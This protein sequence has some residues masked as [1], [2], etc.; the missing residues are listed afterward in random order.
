M[1]SKSSVNLSVLVAGGG[2]MLPT[3]LRKYGLIIPGPNSSGS[4]LGGRNFG[5]VLGRLV[6]FLSVSAGWWCHSGGSTESRRNVNIKHGRV[7]RWHE[8]MKPCQGP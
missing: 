4:N 6:G 8:S 5:C 3:T 7:S 1:G 2:W